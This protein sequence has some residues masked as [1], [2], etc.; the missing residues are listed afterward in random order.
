MVAIGVGVRQNL[1][2]Q[3]GAIDSGKMHPENQSASELLSPDALSIN[4]LNSV[5]VRRRP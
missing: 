5:S 3:R 2:P 4:E 1:D